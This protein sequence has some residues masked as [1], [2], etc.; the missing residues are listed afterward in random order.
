MLAERLAHDLKDALKARDEV[1]VRTLRMLRT[2]IR[3]REDEV[4]RGLKPEEEVACV[5]TAIQRRND[6]AAQ[7]RAGNREELAVAE[8][9]EREVLLRYLPEQLDHVQIM[10][11]IDGAIAELNAAGPRDFGKVMRAAMARIAGRAD[12]A[13]VSGLVRERL[14]AGA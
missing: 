1:V 7:F 3:Y 6:A 8:E 2:E 5:R 10:A 13:T 4:R 12:G 9:A 11:E 14:N